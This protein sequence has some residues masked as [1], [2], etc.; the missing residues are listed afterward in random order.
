[1]LYLKS[2]TKLKTEEKKKMTLATIYIKYK[3]CNF[4][5][6]KILNLKRIINF[7]EITK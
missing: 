1:M 6:Y 4:K 5:R 3:K 7:Y 2:K